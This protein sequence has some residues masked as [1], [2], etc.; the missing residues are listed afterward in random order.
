MATITVNGES[1]DRVADD[2]GRDHVALELEDDDEGDRDDQG[3]LPALV[4]EREQHRGH[5][6]D[7]RSDV[8]NHVEK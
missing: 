6:G 8:R 7:G 2:L 5:E 4:E 1:P 3:V